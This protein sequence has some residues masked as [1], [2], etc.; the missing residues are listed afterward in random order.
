METR[1]FNRLKREMNSFKG[2]IIANLLGAALS[3]AFSLAYGVNKLIP[4]FVEGKLE[5][6]GL[7]YL[8]IVIL[9]FVFAISWIT[10]SAGLMDEHDEI[11]EDLNKI[12]AEDDEA[13]T[14]IIIENLAFYRENQE[15]IMQ[16]AWGSRVTGIFLMLA[17][18]LQLSSAITGNIPF[19]G[20]MFVGQ[21]FALAA[22]IVVGLGALYVPTMLQ[23]FTDKWDVRIRSSDDA[24]ESFDKIL[25]GE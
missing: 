20:I 17:A 4:L 9:G 21:W 25:V 13:I 16:L 24:S 7:P 12:N 10:K 14:S 23:R 6:M 8:G 18:V 5:I 1:A 22:N 2:L 11:V 3:L 19:K 15:K